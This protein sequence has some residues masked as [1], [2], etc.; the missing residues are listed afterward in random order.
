MQNIK[1]FIHLIQHDKAF[2]ITSKGQLWVLPFILG[3]ISWIRDQLFHRVALNFMNYLGALE[4]TPV[5]F[6][7]PQSIDFTQVVVA[8]EALLKYLGKS[9][10]PKVKAAVLKLK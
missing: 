6:N 2:Y 3:K 5:R 4:A 9:S 7:A 10:S 8:S 1:N